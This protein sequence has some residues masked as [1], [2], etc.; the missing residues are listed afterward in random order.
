MNGTPIVCEMFRDG[1]H[2]CDGTNKV[3]L[4]VNA[5]K[6]TSVMCGVCIEMSKESWQSGTLFFEIGDDVTNYFL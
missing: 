4:V 5:D 6:T 1:Y 3:Y 2:W